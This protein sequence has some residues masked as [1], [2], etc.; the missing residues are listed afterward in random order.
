MGENQRKIFKHARTLLKRFDD[1]MNKGKVIEADNIYG[2]LTITYKKLET[3]QVH[4][5]QF[6]AVMYKRAKRAKQKE[7]R[8]SIVN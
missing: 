4:L 5:A 1:A 7:N 3:L 8:Y 2:E 6:C